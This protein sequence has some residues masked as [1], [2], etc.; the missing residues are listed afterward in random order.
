MSARVSNRKCEM[1]AGGGRRVNGM[2]VRAIQL[3][4][5]KETNWI[6]NKRKVG[7]GGLLLV[8]FL[9]DGE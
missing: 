4:W 5:R 3:M 8:G 1:R 2:Q 7:D 9:L 6:K